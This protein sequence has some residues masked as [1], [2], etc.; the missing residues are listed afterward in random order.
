MAAAPADMAMSAKESGQQTR[1][2][3]MAFLSMGL[4][5]SDSFLAFADCRPAL[6]AILTICKLLL[7]KLDA[8]KQCKQIWLEQNKNSWKRQV[9]FGRAIDEGGRLQCT[10]N[11]SAFEKS[12]TSGK[13]PD[14]R[15]RASLSPHSI[16]LSKSCKALTGQSAESLEVT[17]GRQAAQHDRM[18][19]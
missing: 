2:A 13:N 5:G 8:D 16:F 1:V 4:D 10:G 3:L 11:A 9:F 7:E 6:P 18:Q 19:P 12:D 14:V 17:H 15:M